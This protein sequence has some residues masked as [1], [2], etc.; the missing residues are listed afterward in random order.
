MSKGFTLVETMVAIFILSMAIT[1]AMTVAQSSLQSSFYSRD[2]IAAYFLAGEAIEMI[3][4]KR[5]ENGIKNFG[6]PTHWLDGIASWATTPGPCSE[7]VPC[8]VDPI[9]ETI[10][11]CSDPDM[12]DCKLFK[13]SEGLISHE[14]TGGTATKFTRR[15]NMTEINPNEVKVTVSIIWAGRPTFVISEHIFNW[16]PLSD[17]I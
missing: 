1:S 2:R 9:L 11:L 17:L 14:D 13:D 4:N 8:G 16:H 12:N 15:I 5:D 7:A 6:T 10:A 3:K